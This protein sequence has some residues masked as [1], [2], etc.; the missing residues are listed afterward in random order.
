MWKG[1]KEALITALAEG[2]GIIVGRE[3]PSLTWAVRAARQ[4]GDL[5]AL[6][7]GIY[8]DR[9]RAHDFAVRV[10]A[11]LHAD[12]DAILLGSSAEIALG[13]R[14]PA[15]DETVVAA[16]RRIQRSPAGY[17]LTRRRI[18]ADDVI[19][20]HGPDP[21]TAHPDRPAVRSTSPALTAVDLARERGP[22]PLDEALR[23]GI[24]L[25]DLHAALARHPGRGSQ[26]V[27]RLLR[28]SRDEPWS[29]A[30]REGH[31]ALREA[32]VRGWVANLT[33]ERSRGRVAHLDVG[34][35]SLH[36][37]FEIDGY[38]H[39]SSRS[40]FHADRERDTDLARRGWEIHRVSASWVLAE[41]R[42]FAEF[43]A[44]M[45]RQRA[46]LLG[47]PLPRITRAAPPR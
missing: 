13:W 47:K 25:A 31:R 1:V 32:A 23:R 40:A 45:A 39:H 44:Q 21:T 27:R 17:R 42:A 16:S 28:D 46:L 35:A 9:A 20:H 18:H 7:C 19:E 6:Q 30:E 22:D 11:L 14:E 4:R 37:G 3:H 24:A 33:V 43:V 15:P 12:P 36:L 26:A 29:A 10:L 5:V 41:P 2:G 34:L 38:A 8:T